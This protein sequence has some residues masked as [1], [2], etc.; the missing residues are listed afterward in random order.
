MWRCAML[1]TPLLACG[2]EGRCPREL[3]ERGVPF[4]ATAHLDEQPP[5][6]PDLTCRVESPVLLGPTVRGVTFRSGYDGGTEALF[7]SCPLALAIDVAAA[8]L[9]RRGVTE[10]SHL[11]TYQ[12]R[13]IEGASPAAST[14]SQHGLANAIDLSGFTLDGGAGYTVQAAWEKNQPTPMT[15]GGVFLKELAGALFDGG[16]SIVLTPDF[17]DAHH[18]HFHLDLTPGVRLL[19]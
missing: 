7:V 12:C 13:T 4:T 18:D 1:L 10:A 8:L 15:P 16:F 14:L 11:G 19:R 17:N 9:E 3:A 5:G 6:R 2:D